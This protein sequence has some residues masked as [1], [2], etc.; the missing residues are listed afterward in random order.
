VKLKCTIACF[1]IKNK[2]ACAKY[3]CNRW[4][5]EIYL[6]CGPR[7]DPGMR[8]AF[9][10]VRLSNS[11]AATAESCAGSVNEDQSTAAAPKFVRQ[12]APTTQTSTI[13]CRPRCI[14]ISNEGLCVPM[15][16]P[17]M[18]ADNL[19]H[20]VLRKQPP[21]TTPIQNAK[22]G[23]WHARQLKNMKMQAGVDDSCCLEFSRSPRCAWAVLISIN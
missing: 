1:L 15:S 4:K 16:V 12:I 7:T 19:G 5:T 20:H 9:S 22:S 8:D 18:T 13:L 6:C 2:I 21:R 14:I 23:I 17:K 11:L 3:D 10:T